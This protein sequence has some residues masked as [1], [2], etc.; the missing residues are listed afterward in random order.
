MNDYKVFFWVLFGF[1]IMLTFNVSMQVR[2]NTAETISIIRDIESNISVLENNLDV[3]KEIKESFHSDPIFEWPMV[4]DDYQRLTDWYGLR[5]I[6]TELYKGGSSTREHTG[7]DIKGEGLKKLDVIGFEKARIT[8][9][10]DGEVISHHLPPGW[11]SGKY[12]SGDDI[13]GGKI[14]IDHKNGWFSIY[15]HMDITYVHEG[16]WV[17]IK[18]IIG[19]QGNTG[20]STGPHLHFELWY[21]WESPVQ[22]LIYLKNPNVLKQ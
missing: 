6:P 17:T 16:Q 22:P 2:Q 1:L 11:Y 12:Y 18:D 3:Y 10:G 19:R 21:G 20:M 4:L 9:I 13:L 14:I 7:L 15:G 8:P 5:S